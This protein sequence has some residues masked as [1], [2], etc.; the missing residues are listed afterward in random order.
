[1][2]QLHLLNTCFN[3]LQSLSSVFKPTVGSFFFHIFEMNKRKDLK[4]KNASEN[5]F[6]NWKMQDDLKHIH[7]HLLY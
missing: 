2:I 1:M 7:T 3:C 5:Y 6:V 4:R